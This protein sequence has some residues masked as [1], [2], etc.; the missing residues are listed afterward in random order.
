[1]PRLVWV[2]LNSYLLT[3]CETFK[4]F[5]LETWPPSLSVGCI[6]GHRLILTVLGIEP[7]EIL[8]TTKR[9]WRTSLCYLSWDHFSRAA[10]SA[11]PC[12]PQ[13]WYQESITVIAQD[14]IRLALIFWS[15]KPQERCEKNKDKEEHFLSYAPCTSWY[16]VWA[17]WRSWPVPQCWG[18]GC[19][20]AGC[21]I[22]PGPEWCSGPV[23]GLALGAWV[24]LWMLI[25]GRQWV[26]CV[27]TLSAGNILYHHDSCFPHLFR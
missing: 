24:P 22:L 26:W 23:G 20:F 12:I 13:L 1:M 11:G 25:L 2:H 9:L 15:R 21:M 14:G 5:S 17:W 7:K 6:L 18:E 19:S 10:V 8:A 27:R 16:D 3:D 4:V